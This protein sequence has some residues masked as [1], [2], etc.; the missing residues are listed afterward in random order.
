MYKTQTEF[1]TLLHI[2]FRLCVFLISPE[3]EMTTFT[4]SQRPCPPKFGQQGNQKQSVI[5]EQ[6]EIMDQITCRF[7]H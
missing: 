1:S 6:H 7:D 4:D 2:K 3:R 5:G